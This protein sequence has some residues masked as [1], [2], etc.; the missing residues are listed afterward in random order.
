M[1]GWVG[2]LSGWVGGWIEW[3]GGCVMRWRFQRRWKKE[4]NRRKG[5]EII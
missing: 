3:V 1:S 2:G 4:G 5:K